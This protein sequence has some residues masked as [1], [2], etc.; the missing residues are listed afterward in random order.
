[1]PLL[2][3]R[4]ELKY[5]I[6]GYDV[7]EEVI[8]DRDQM[9]G[10]GGGRTKIPWG[11]LLVYSFQ[12]GGTSERSCIGDFVQSAGVETLCVVRS[13]KNYLTVPRGQTVSVTCRVD[14]GPLEEGTPVFLTLFKIQPGQ[15]A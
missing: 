3:A 5:P 7:I 10:G 2:V 6:V 11:R 8:K 14:C 13:G 15:M 12:R 4:D 9:G 1:M